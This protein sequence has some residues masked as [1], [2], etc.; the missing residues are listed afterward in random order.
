MAAE[1]R[2]ATVETA[3][4]TAGEEQEA[5]EIT[6]EFDSKEDRDRGFYC[7]LMESNSQFSSMGD[8]FMVTASQCAMLDSRGIK[9]HRVAAT[10]T[11][12]V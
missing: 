5:T 9:Y 12:S 6:V 11:T 10:T 4:A 1:K 7:L 8:R 2:E 3:A